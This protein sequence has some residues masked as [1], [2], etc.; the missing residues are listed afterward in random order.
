MKNGT[1]VVVDGYRKD[2]WTRLRGVGMN[3]NFGGSC[4]RPT[5]DE[6]KCNGEG[7]MGDNN[8]EGHSGFRID[9]LSANVDRWMDAY[10]PQIIL[11]MAGIND[12]AQ[13]YEL[14]N[15]TASLGIPVWRCS[16]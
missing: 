4:P 7:T 12:I 6:W 15:A 5:W 13:N 3:V 14:P 10:Q 8:H 16:S 2:L 1:P 11:L 9:Q